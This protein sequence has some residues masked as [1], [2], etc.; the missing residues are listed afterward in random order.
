ME[1]APGGDPL[2]ELDD[3]DLT[4]R[5]RTGLGVSLRRLGSSGHEKA[6]DGRRV[7]GALAADTGVDDLAECAFMVVF[8]A[9]PPFP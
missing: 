4:L 7:I 6:G 8:F 2:R 9:A 5:A 3:D 1:P